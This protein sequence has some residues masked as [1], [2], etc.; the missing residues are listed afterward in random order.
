VVSAR[1]S[2]RALWG[3]CP[4]VG[5]H[6]ISGKVDWTSRADCVATS[7]AGSNFDRIF[8]VE[9]PEGASVRGHSP[10][11]RSSRGKISIELL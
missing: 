11:Y 9:T 1:Q 3:R 5:E 8:P 4:A 10:D 6:D 2:S 7:V